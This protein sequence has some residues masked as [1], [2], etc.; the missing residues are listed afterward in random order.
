MNFDYYYF[1][2]NC[3]YRLLELL[4]VARPGTELTDEFSHFGEKS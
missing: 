2:E 3:S 4:E 1:D